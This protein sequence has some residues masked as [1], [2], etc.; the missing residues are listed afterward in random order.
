MLNRA[1]NQ[2]QKFAIKSILSNVNYK[3]KREKSK[4]RITSKIISKS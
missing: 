3:S 4:I 2:I 1:R